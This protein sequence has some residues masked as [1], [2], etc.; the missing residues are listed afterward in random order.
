VGHLK[1]HLHP[2]PFRL[3]LTLTEEEFSRAPYTIENSSHRRVIL[4]ELERVRALGV[5][6]PQ[7]LWEYKVSRGG[8]LFV[9]LDGEVGARKQLAITFL[10]TV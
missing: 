3:L 6:P 9:C 10:L 7:N 1:S 5:K 4:T 8:F 2:P